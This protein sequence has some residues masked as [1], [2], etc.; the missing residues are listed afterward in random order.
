MKFR[1]LAAAIPVALALALE[2]S[3][4]RALRHPGRTRRIR[5][6]QSAGHG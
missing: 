4:Q 1:K 2:R 6:A 5:G 3:G